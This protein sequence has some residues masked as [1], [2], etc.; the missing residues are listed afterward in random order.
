MPWKEPGKGDKDPWSSGGQQPPDL[1]EVFRNLNN[2]LRSIFGGSRARKS[3]SDGGS[4]GGSGGLF[5]ILLV[6]LLLWVGWDSVH[7][8]DEAEQGVVLR[9]GAYNRTLSPGINLTL[10]RPVEA[11]IK[12][13]VSNVRSLEDRG[14]MLTEDENLVEF[15]Y[16]VQYR[17]ASAQDFLFKVR[18]PE[19]TVRDA[20]ESALRESVGTNRLDA[21]LEGTQR[22]QVRLE[23][24]R[25]LQETLD[26][27][28]AGVQV[29]QFN[30]TDVNVP[31]QVR[32]AYSDVIRAREDR[33]RFIEEARVHVNSVV[34]E[35]RGQAARIEQEAEGYKA[36]TVALA[37]G[38]AQRFRLLLD[39]YLKAPEITRK[40]LYL[41]T[42]EG[43]F[44][45]SRKV[46]LDTDNSG[47]V[48]YLPL[49]Q[50]SGG[51]AGSRGQMP[52]VVTPEGPIGVDSGPS[53]RDSRREGRQ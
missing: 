42:M 43:V 41:Q 7:I 24:F 40:R 23:T 15:N 38:E 34:P 47:N 22:E 16:K 39:E 28:Q 3:G 36:A 37:E 45:R 19:S 10:P 1:E 50:L 8:I 30:F 5:P 46:L 9:F 25:V 13:N 44:S 29:T 32:E 35:A 18:E 48:L 20:A 33:E 26:R 12:V 49:D 53:G 27:Y 4:G 11:M 17:V 52:P 2:R 21:I 14:H 51:A 6:A 31:A